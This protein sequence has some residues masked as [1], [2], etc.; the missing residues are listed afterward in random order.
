MDFT[1]RFAIAP[2]L[3]ALVWLATALGASA[4][5]QPIV[6]ND[7]GAWCWFQ[8]ERA[9]IH[10]GRLMVGSVADSALDTNRRGDI[11]VTVVDLASGRATRSEL[12]D[13]LEDDDH[14]VPALWVRPNGQ[15]VAL[16]AKHGGENH[17]YCRVSD[18][19][20][21]DWGP[22][23]KF[24][25]SDASRVTY[26]N[27]L[28][29]AAEN[30]GQG[31]LYNFYRG[32]NASFKPSFAWSDDQGESWQSGNVVIDVPTEFRHRPYVKYTSNG[33]DT[34]HL[35]YTDGHPRNFDNNVYHVYYRD[36]K[37][38]RSDGT[39][40]RALADGL[41]EPAEGTRLFHGDADNVGWVSDTHLSP[42]GQPYV[43]F[44]VQKDGAG[45]PSGDRAAGQDHRYHY[46]HWDGR[47]WRDHEIA[48]AGSRLYVGE[49]DYTGNI[50][51]HPDRLDTVFI[52]TNADPATGKP[53]ISQ[54]DDKRH[55]E[56][57][58][59][60]TSDE[61]RSWNWRPI[62]HD[63]TVDNLRPI[64]PKWNADHTVLLWFRGTYRSYRDF[65]T[66]VVM[67]NLQP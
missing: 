34:I 3:A 51:L 67:L 56:L 14:D 19:N 39:P 18:S 7:N 5:E 54:A 37:L 23:Q 53:L 60:Q 40:I 22:L 2:G 47:T 28:F 30:D 42:A 17:F 12:F 66:E 48:Y 24:T 26:A 10:D 29:L 15:V 4:A 8:D 6:V 57:F 27:L 64:V 13:Q 25:P 43:V 21:N 65:Q 11:E 32:L 9:V 46:A 62:T 38:H 63:S 55:Y 49:D 1:V 36:G 61:G 20:W 50:C 41:R 33:R 59:G 16:F 45:L 31:R 52:S 35:L 44:S 58:R